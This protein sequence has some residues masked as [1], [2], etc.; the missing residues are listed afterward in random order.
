MG[1]RKLRLRSPFVLSMNFV[2]GS[3]SSIPTGRKGGQPQPKTTRQGGWCGR[4]G[5][6]FLSFLSL[7]RRPVLPSVLSKNEKDAIHLFK[8]VHWWSAGRSVPPCQS[9]GWIVRVVTGWASCFPYWVE[10]HRCH[11][12]ARSGI[13][14]SLTEG[15]LLMIRCPRG[16]GKEAWGKGVVTDQ[17]GGR[18]GSDCREQV[19]LDDHC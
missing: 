11:D 9:Y 10:R 18:V 14:S 12:G 8:F 7:P 6:R 17:G 16:L 5:C 1:K 19:R 15:I 3:V 2:P 4:Q 13:R